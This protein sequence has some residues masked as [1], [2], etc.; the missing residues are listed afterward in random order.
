MQFATASEERLDPPIHVQ[1]DGDRKA[2][3]IHFIQRVSVETLLSF[4]D[5]WVSETLTVLVK[6]DSP[7]STI[8]G[9]TYCRR[10]GMCAVI[11]IAPE[12]DDGDSAANHGADAGERRTGK[13]AAKPPCPQCHQTDHVYE[14]RQKGGWFCWKSKGGCGH[15][16]LP[17]SEAPPTEEPFGAP[18]DPK[19]RADAI[20]KRHG[21][22]TADKLD[23]PP[24]LSK[25]ETGAFGYVETFDRKLA[26]AD[27]D[28]KLDFMRDWLLKNRDHFEKLFESLENWY[29]AAIDATGPNDHERWEQLS[30]LLEADKVYLKDTQIFQV[31]VR[32]D[33]KR[34]VVGAT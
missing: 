21:M 8:L 17:D 22:T 15:N 28:A 34:A 23:R 5:Q 9:E 6:D 29:V 3:T 33:K 32:R 18:P 26:A 14:D 19:A 13:R 27:S 20:A 12:D 25:D 1:A 10:G 4:E 30:R 11:G 24:K 2:K 16:W 7:Q 31:N